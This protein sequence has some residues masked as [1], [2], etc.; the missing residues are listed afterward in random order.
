[1]SGEDSLSVEQLE[2][3]GKVLENPVAKS[4]ERFEQLR[5]AGCRAT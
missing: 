5:R 2:N 1:M 3:L 4:E